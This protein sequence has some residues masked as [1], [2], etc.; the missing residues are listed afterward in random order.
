MNMEA[1]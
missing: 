1:A